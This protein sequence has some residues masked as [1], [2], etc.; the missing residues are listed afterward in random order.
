[1]LNFLKIIILGIIE[2]ITEWLPISSTGHMLLAEHFLKLD[3]SA[4]FMEM[5]RV[6]IQF[7]AIIAVI[8]LFWN[9]LW[10][11]HKPD[12]KRSGL[13]R[14]MSKKKFRLWIMILISCLPAIA[15]G[16][17]FDDWLDEHLYNYVVVA[18]MLIVYGVLFIVVEK[19]KSSSEPLMTKL[20]E[21]DVRTALL[22]GVFQVLALIPGTSRSGA[23]ILGGLILGLSRPLAAQYT[24]F[25]A[26]PVMAGAS[27]LKLVKFGL[28]FTGIELLYLLTGMAVA[29]AVSYFSIKFLMSYVRRHDFKVFG[30][31]RIVLGVVVLVY[32][33]F[34]GR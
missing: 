1:M 13:W 7:G 4:E 20:T 8:I 6:V 28:H 12:P 29:F 17:P 11:F 31:Y 10:P 18:I 9:K 27:L 34:A 2:G 16:L 19:W 24:F 5:F 32:F 25:L 33:F 21:I 22:I 23:T 3:V 15:I 26:V 14:I 30:W